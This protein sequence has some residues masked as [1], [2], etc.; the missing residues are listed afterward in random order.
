MRHADPKLWGQVQQTLANARGRTGHIGNLDGNKVHIVDGNEV[1]TRE[2]QDGDPTSHMDFVEGGNDLEAP[3]VK[4]EFGKNSLLIDG[5]IHPESHPYILYHE[6]HERR[7]MA[8]GHSY[9]KAH[10]SA[11]KAELELRKLNKRVTQ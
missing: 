5:R 1:K 7:L 11:N 2:D 10:E 6:A 3:W 9:E 8:K 4:K